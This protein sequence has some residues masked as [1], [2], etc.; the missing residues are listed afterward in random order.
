MTP[1]E[2][3]RDGDRPLSF[4]GDLLSS[5]TTHRASK[6]VWTEL[7]LF[8]T[9]AGTFV[10]QTVG[11]TCDPGKVDLFAA[12]IY[13]TAEELYDGLCVKGGRLSAPARELLE[14]AAEEHEDIDELLDNKLS[15]PEHIA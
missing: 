13:V 14:L 11:R 3:E 7:S 15:E 12:D 8:V 1:Y 6:N 2:L 4:D 9:A 10:V 5:A